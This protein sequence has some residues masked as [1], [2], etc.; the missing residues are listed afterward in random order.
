MSA[1]ILAGFHVCFACALALAGAFFIQAWRLRRRDVDYLLFGL[2]SV[3]L[4]GYAAATAW[5]SWGAAFE[6]TV[7]FDDAVRVMAASAVTAVALLLHFALRYA[8]VANERRIVAVAYPVFGAILAALFVG[9]GWVATEEMVRV[10]HV[11]G[12]DVPLVDVR[13]SSTGV[14]FIAIVVV[15]VVAMLTLIGMTSFRDRE[16]SV[17]P[18]VGAAVLAITMLN[19][20]LG[21]GVG[22]YDTIIAAPFG[23]V[24]FVYAMSLALVDRY[25]LF[26]TVL[27][28]RSVEL[29]QRTTQL[30][31]SLDELEQ[32]QQELLQREQLAMVGEL[33]SV[34]THEV[35]NPMAIVQNAVAGLRGGGG[36]GDDDTRGL[37][38]I[39]EDEMSRL[40]RLVTNLLVL[41]RP[42]A[43]QRNPLELQ[44]LLDKSLA[45]VDAYP[46]VDVSVETTG[47]WPRVEV[48]AE[49]MRQVLANVFLNAVEAMDGYGELRVEVSGTRLQGRAAVRIVVDDSGEGMTAEELEHARTP[50]FTTRAWGTGLGLALCDSIVEAHGGTLSLDSSPGD[51]T[52][53]TII[54]PEEFD[55]TASGRWRPRDP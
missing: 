3:A 51:G 38:G 22:L 24:L 14:V 36:P 35:R 1:Q 48:D 30:A 6:G 45:V 5:L 26:A 34:I 29:A 9:P 50:F 46:H 55:A 32:T 39:I 15:V 12:V 17:A 8:N 40:D 25:V 21:I 54:L 23:F 53:V 41:A 11:L 31:R 16:R 49:L 28:E 18:F 10:T 52:R 47:P 13:L 42:V 33:A 44:A 27:G 43:P 37:L 4:G 20:G 2:T 7:D 19:D